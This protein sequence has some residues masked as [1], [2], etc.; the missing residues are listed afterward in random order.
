M[1]LA[2]EA[3]EKET[4]LLIPLTEKPV[5]SQSEKRESTTKEPET[6]MTTPSKGSDSTFFTI[7]K[8]VS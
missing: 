4:S 1:P 3:H 6:T 5:V 7:V 8:R 2:Q